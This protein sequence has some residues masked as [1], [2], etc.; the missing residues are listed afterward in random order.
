MKSSIN[1]ET[2][3]TEI[4]LSKMQMV[5]VDVSQ[6]YIQKVTNKVN[7]NCH[8]IYY[9]T[10]VYMVLKDKSKEIKY[11]IN[12]LNEGFYVSALSVRSIFKYIKCHIINLYIFC[13]KQSCFLKVHINKIKKNQS[14]DQKS[15]QSDLFILKKI[16]LCITALTNFEEW[17]S[18]IMSKVPRWKQM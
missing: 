4:I 15:F 8:V 10:M 11:L 14:E 6:L 5:A 7:G 3:I 12:L 2:K 18:L 13:F 17:E 1:V 9:L 16:L